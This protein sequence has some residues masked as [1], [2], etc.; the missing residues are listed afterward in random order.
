MG[1]RIEVPNELYELLQQRAAQLQRSPE[2]LAAEALRRSLSPGDR[3]WETRLQQ[4][5]AETHERPDL[6]A[7]EEIEADISA[8]AAE[9]RELRRERRRLA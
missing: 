1:Q 3:A 2:Q 9:A 5:L 8:A 4:L 7:P 6:P